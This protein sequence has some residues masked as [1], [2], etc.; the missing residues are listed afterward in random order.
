[1]VNRL[2]NDI[3]DTAKSSPANRNLKNEHQLKITKLKSNNTHLKKSIQIFSKK[4]IIL[5]TQ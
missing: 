5:L 4:K 1:M 2:P 3:N